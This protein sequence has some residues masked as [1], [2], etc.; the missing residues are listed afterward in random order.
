MTKKE[1]AKIVMT[2]LEKIYPEVPIP[3]NHKNA[4]E[5]LVAVAL[6]AQ[7]TDKKVN[8]VTPKLFSVA[9]IL[10]K[11]QLWKNLKLKN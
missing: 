4:Y 6:S 2:E 3:L 5:L 7:T 9:P 1:R 10:K 11:W 8:E